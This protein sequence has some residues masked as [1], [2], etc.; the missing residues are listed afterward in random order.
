MLRGNLPRISKIQKKL[1]TLN[2]AIAAYR[3]V[4]ISER[5]SAAMESLVAIFTKYANAVAIVEKLS[6][7]GATPEEIDAQVKISDGPA[8]EALKVVLPPYN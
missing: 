6:L 3:S 5:E 2:T 8:V 4:G 1:D 7:Q